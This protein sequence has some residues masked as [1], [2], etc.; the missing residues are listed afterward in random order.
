MKISVIK[1]IFAVLLIIGC[2]TSTLAFDAA[3]ADGDT[4]VS[5][6]L[7]AVL[8]EHEQ[9]KVFTFQSEI[10]Q[11]QK[12]IYVSL[13]PSYGQGNRVY[14][15][16]YVLD[17]EFLFDLT[18]SISR[19]K[20]ARYD[21]PESI[22]VGLT[23]G[24]DSRRNMSLKTKRNKS[25]KRYFFNGDAKKY[26][27]VIESELIPLIE[28]KYASHAKQSHRTII[29]MSP[30]LGPVFE[31]LWSESELF[32]GFIGLSSHYLSQYLESGE[33]VADKILKSFSEGSNSQATLYL[34]MAE[35]DVEN[36][37]LETSTYEKLALA[38]KNT[39][40]QSN[41]KLEI[42]KGEYHYLMAIPGIQRGLNLIFPRRRSFQPDYEKFSQMDD[43]AAAVKAFYERRSKSLGYSLLPE[44][45]GAGNMKINEL[46][47]WLINNKRI[48]EAIA[49]FKLAQEYYPNNANLFDSL[50]DAYQANGQHD[51][52]LAAVKRAIR[53]TKEHPQPGLNYLNKRLEKLSSN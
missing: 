23:N 18:V 22:I 43:P 32:K 29:G 47:Y 28:N 13:P 17:A 19:F 7:N 49:V 11:N 16:I 36:Y 33:M 52:E 44:G 24:A 35:S 14:P 1:Y 41:H 53:L 30:T 25:D 38:L 8:T 5:P 51:A 4:I 34:A 46:G 48:K 39:S 21:M 12:K 2:S 31:S 45:A 27:K 9:K 10:L 37:P 42:L 15:V 3:I 40:L 26:L 6:G 50:A 20:A